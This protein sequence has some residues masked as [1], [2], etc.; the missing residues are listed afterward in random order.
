MRHP[1]PVLGVSALNSSYSAHPAD[2]PT[3]LIVGSAPD[4]WS[5]IPS[6]PDVYLV[7]VGDRLRFRYTTEH[8]VWLFK[9]LKAFEACD[10]GAASELAGSHYGGG[11]A[12]SPNMYEA[13]AL[14]PGTLFIA[15]EVAGHCKAGQKLRIAVE[16]RQGHEPPAL[17]SSRN[18]STIRER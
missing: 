17:Q 3:I 15:C 5:A 9:S 4:Y 2:V 13:T 7:R 16:A 6:V 12:A 10:F 11:D 8:N 1:S 14:H 18:V